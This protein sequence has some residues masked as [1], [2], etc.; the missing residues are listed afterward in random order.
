MAP[1]KKNDGYT[2]SGVHR[3]RARAARPPRVR[4]GDAQRRKS[5]HR[6]SGR[7][8]SRSRSN[9]PHRAREH[10]P[11]D[12]RQGSIKPARRMRWTRSR[13]SAAAGR[14][15][16]RDGAPLVQ[17]EAGHQVGAPR[18]HDRQTCRRHFRSAFRAK[19]AASASGSS[20]VG[21]WV[22]AARRTRNVAL[23]QVH[24]C[25][26]PRAA[27]PRRRS[28]WK[29]FGSRRA[30][31]VISRGCRQRAT[32]DRRRPHRCVRAAER[33][34]EGRFSSWRSMRAMV[35]RAPPS[36][37]RS[38]GLHAGGNVD[39]GV[40]GAVRKDWR[41]PRRREGHRR[42]LRVG[43]ARE[44]VLLAERFCAAR[45]VARRAE[46]SAGGD[47]APRSR[48]SSTAPDARGSPRGVSRRWRSKRRTRS[49][50]IRSSAKA[51][52]RAL[53]RASGGRA[54][55]PRS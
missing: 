46:R 50:A 33:T 3:R 1:G 54:V 43:R 55:E 12:R 17:S 23:A 42:D 11:L 52:L 31:G 27:A 38:T 30:R 5:G 41:E 4:R 49:R 29:A 21:S 53:T 13:V 19:G 25:A 34:V 16:A 8:R 40:R 2:A 14:A 36:S 44:G 9:R 18:S 37:R 35:R 15:R 51:A 47:G 24:S 28:R 26:R 10:R 48:G 6:D 22:R 32:G 7:F 45:S 39:R 20:C